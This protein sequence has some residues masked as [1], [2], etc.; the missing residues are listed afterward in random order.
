MS[1]ISWTFGPVVVEIDG[2]P[3]MTAKCLHSY[4]ACSGYNW[5]RCHWND[6]RFDIP[7]DNKTPDACKFKADALRDAAGMANGGSTA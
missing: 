3:G 6:E 4:L 2:E 1:G 5:G 7:K